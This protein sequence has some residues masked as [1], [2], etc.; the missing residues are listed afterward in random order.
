MEPFIHEKKSERLR[1]AKEMYSRIRKDEGIRGIY[2]F[3]HAMFAAAR[4]DE[5][6]YSDAM[7]VV[8][9]LFY[10][11]ERAS[12]KNRKPSAKSQ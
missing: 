6:R 7:A 9:V 10:A 4:Q 12:R 11:H 3:R 8:N 1:R 2:Q 5:Y